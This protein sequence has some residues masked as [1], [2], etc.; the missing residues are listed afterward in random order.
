[1][2]QTDE[3]DAEFT[4]GEL[5]AARRPD[6]DTAPGEDRVT[7]SM[8]VHLGPAGDEAFLCETGA[9]RPISLVS[10]MGKTAE[11]MVLNRLLWNLGP[12]NEHIY[13]YRKG[14]GTAHRIA[15]PLAAMS[16]EP[17]ITIFLDLEKTFEL[18]SP[19]AIQDT[20]ARKGRVVLSPTFLNVL[21]SNVLELP[22]P[23]GC[24]IISYALIIDGKQLCYD[25]AQRCFDVVAAECVRIGLKIS[26][27]KSK[28]MAFGLG[29]GKEPLVT[30]G[31]ALDWVSH[32]Q[33]LDEWVDKGLTFNRETSHLKD[34]ITARTTV[35]RPMCG[36]TLG[37]MHQF[38][39]M[40]Y[41]QAVR[42]IADYAAPALLTVAAEKNSSGLNYAR[43]KRL[44]SSREHNLQREASLLPLQL[45]IRM[46]G[47]DFVGRK[48][49]PPPQAR[50]VY[51]GQSTPH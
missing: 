21:I 40:Y 7:Y 30:Q 51:V 14:S 2:A 19:L 28:A 23:H 12:L 22:L 18:A 43:M 32:F 39:C 50:Q 17:S 37:A 3:T 31:Y 20:L 45:R 41:V 24:K 25:R 47:A 46:L 44:E 9:Y 48:P 33:Y 26:P 11:R 4:L 10:C 27:R 5:T 16:S 36:R 49:P 42:S 8:L 34:R 13:T 29:R 35:M 1:M 15:T 6:K 38:L